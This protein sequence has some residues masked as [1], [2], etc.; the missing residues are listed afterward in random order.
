MNEIGA[1]VG[2]RGIA[3]QFRMELVFD[4]ES[5][6]AIATRPIHLAECDRA[7]ATTAFEAFRK[8][9]VPVYEPAPRKA[10]VAPLFAESGFAAV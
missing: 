5:Q 2:P 7:L 9:A 8:G 4:A 10:I 3:T 6:L 1:A